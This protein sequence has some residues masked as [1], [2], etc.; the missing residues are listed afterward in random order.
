MVENR[1][2]SGGNGGGRVLM[3]DRGFSEKWWFFWQKGVGKTGKRGGKLGEKR[4]KVWFSEQ[5][6]KNGQKMAH[7]SS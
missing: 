6:L 1:G 5:V 3:V 4:E 2:F 7:R